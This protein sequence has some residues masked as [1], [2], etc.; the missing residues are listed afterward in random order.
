MASEAWTWEPSAHPRVV[1]LLA[2]SVADLEWCAR[3]ED[4]PTDPV[5]GKVLCVC[6]AAAI[7]REVLAAGSGVGPAAAA[8]LALLSD[9]IDDPTEERLGRICGI[10]FPP[11]KSPD[12]DPYGLV[13]WAL[14]TATSTAE[15]Y[16]EAGWALETTCSGALRAGYSPDQLRTIA[17]H[18]ALSRQRGLG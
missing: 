5:V 3:L 15:G 13:W 4:A 9:W 11:N 18:T 8:A 6:A 14:R 12:L 10:I 7:A 16:G 1:N 2:E 17:R